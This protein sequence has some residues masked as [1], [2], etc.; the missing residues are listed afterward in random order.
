MSEVNALADFDCE[1]AMLATAWL[2]NDFVM[3]MRLD[4]ADFVLPFHRWLFKHLRALVE[5]DEPLD[6]IAL[7]RRLRKPGAYDGLTKLEVD[8]A[9]GAIA[10]TLNA[11]APPSHVEFYFRTLR[12][13]RL[14]RFIY[15]VLEEM[16]KRLGDGHE[17]AAVMS[18][19]VANFD[20]ALLKVPVKRETA[21]AEPTVVG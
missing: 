9:K 10:E 1:R 6:M 2:A 5:D 20:R 19:G 8:A 3:V 12:E 16:R 15:R 18:Y 14:K 17:A 7:L 11:W 21:S 13:E 4:E